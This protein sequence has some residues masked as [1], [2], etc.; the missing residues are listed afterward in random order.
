[1]RSFRAAD[2][3]DDRRRQRDDGNDSARGEAMRNRG[4]EKAFIGVSRIWS[5]HC[6]AC[7][8]FAAA[9]WTSG[10]VAA[11]T[12]KEA[13]AQTAAQDAV[14]ASPEEI[15]LGQRLFE[16]SVRFAKGGPACNACHHVNHPTLGAGGILASDLTLSFSRMGRE[17]L[18]AMLAEAPFPVMQVAYAE[19]AVSPEEIRALAGFLQRADA[20]SAAQP[21]AS[22]G[23]K[24]FFGGAGGVVVLAGFFALIGGRRK[25]GSVNQDI[26]DRQIKSE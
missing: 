18:D 24:M 3:R 5:M 4:Q 21:V 6:L 14:K 7:V 26:Y 9:C 2:A 17:G 15:R 8:L 16:G 25:Q 12:D 19:K 23:W 10:A 22:H 1:V 13:P 20:E 11:A